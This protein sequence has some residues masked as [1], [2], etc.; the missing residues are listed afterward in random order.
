MR[1]LWNVDKYPPNKN[2]G[3]GWYAHELNKH[4]LSQGHEVTVM[5]H[6]GEPYEFEG[7]NVI[8][9]DFRLYN[10]ADIVF[11]HT[12]QTDITIS[13]CDRRNK[14][15]VFVSHNT[16]DYPMV[17]HHHKVGVVLNSHHAL[18]ECGYD[19]PNR[20]RVVLPPPVDIDYYKGPVGDCYTLI[21]LCDNKGPKT[22]YEIAEIMP[23]KRF[24]GV[25]GG[26]HMQDVRIIPN[27]EILPN[28][29]DIRDVYKRTRILLMPSKYESWGRTATEAMASGIPVIC[30]PN[31]GLQENCGDAGTYVPREK[32]EDWVKAIN[33]IEKK[34]KTYSKRASKRAESLRTDFTEFD[35]FLLKML[36]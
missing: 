26:Y 3:S 2:D 21:N 30:H 19:Q 16:F 9:G 4:F 5:L 17:R 33:E 35:L 27:V 11:T 1:I 29:A 28:T 10:T 14:P 31:F 32:P 18:K 8:P 7:V 23:D 6:T 20:R 12:T 13:E 36:Q 34:Y 15:C 24:I 22:F 25:R